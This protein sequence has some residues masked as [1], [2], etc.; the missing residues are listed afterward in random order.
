M[1]KVLTEILNLPGIIVESYQQTEETLILSVKANKKT[2]VCPKCGQNSHRLHQN[3]KRLVK[4]LP[5]GNKEV[6]L[7]VNRRRF[8]CE[9]CQKPFSE[10]LN[11][12]G[13]RK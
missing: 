5:I 2:A 4:D 10:V 12:V 9:N 1:N 11:F 3:K 8:K 13:N 6:F 7:R